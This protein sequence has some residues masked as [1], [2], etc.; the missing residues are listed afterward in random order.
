MKKP[1]IY[2]LTAGLA[3]SM[4]ANTGTVN[5]EETNIV[6]DDSEASVNFQGGLLSVSSLTD[7]L[8]FNSEKIVEDVMTS[9]STTALD[10]TVTDFRGTNSG[11]VLSAGLDSFKDG[12]NDSLTGAGITLTNGEANSL[13]TNE[14]VGTLDIVDEI[15]LKSGGDPELILAASGAE[16]FVDA[17]GRGT[18]NLKW[19]E[20]NLQ[21]EVPNAMASAG[22]HTATIDWTIENTPTSGE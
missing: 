3:V 6:N 21:L 12:E 11:W 1:F 18:W 22:D 5:A 10:L 20:D 15:T 7:N 4:I 14:N 9:K 16:N 17:Q 8:A 2:L 13:E 19:L